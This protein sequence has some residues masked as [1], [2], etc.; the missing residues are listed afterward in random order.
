MMYKFL[1]SKKSKFKSVWFN[2]KTETE[3]AHFVV[4]RLLKTTVKKREGVGVGA[5]VVL[6]VLS[7][8]AYGE[9]EK[10]GR[11]IF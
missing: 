2:C 1:N 6:N 10:R 3:G 11:K 9:S 5:C 8:G 4:G 7:V